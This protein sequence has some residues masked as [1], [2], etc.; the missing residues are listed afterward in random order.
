MYLHFSHTAY[1]LF[2]YIYTYELH[3]I[4]G[5]ING[6]TDRILILIPSLC[7]LMSLM[8]INYIFIRLLSDQWWHRH[9]A[10]VE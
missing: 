2:I 5:T 3:L 1:S 7:I 4:L 6:G 9:P 8:L 10:R